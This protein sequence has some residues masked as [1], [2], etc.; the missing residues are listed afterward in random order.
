MPLPSRTPSRHWPPIAPCC[1]A[2]AEQ[3]ERV[4]R[5][6]SGFRHLQRV[7]SASTSNCPPTDVMA[8]PETAAHRIAILIPAFNEE[9]VVGDVVTA[10]RRLYAYP[11]IVID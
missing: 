7:Y 9:A 3:E 1:I 10:L 8:P 5:K 4:L 6:T 11:I 2:W